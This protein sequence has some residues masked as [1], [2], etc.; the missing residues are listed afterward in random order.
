L[1]AGQYGR[2]ASAAGRFGAD[3]EGRRS[4][5]DRRTVPKAALG[6]GGEG[7]REQ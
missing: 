5:P 3:P 7:A 1:T 6:S 2:K 4:S